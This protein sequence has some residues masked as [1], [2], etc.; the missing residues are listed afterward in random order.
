ML[1]SYNRDSDSECDIIEIRYSAAGQVLVF[2]ISGGITNFVVDFLDVC[3]K[4]ETDEVWETSDR[5]SHT[6]ANMSFWWMLC[7]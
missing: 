4:C 1:R 3:L 7:Q 5:E 6:A 2:M